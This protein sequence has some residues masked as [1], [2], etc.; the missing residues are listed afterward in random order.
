MSPLI[1]LHDPL[2]LIGYAGMTAPGSIAFLPLFHPA[3]PHQSLVLRA[4]LSR[5]LIP[6]EHRAKFATTNGDAPPTHVETGRLLA[7]IPS[8][9][10][11]NLRGGVESRDVVY[12]VLVRRD[13]YDR[14][15][16]GI[17]TPGV[18]AG[19]IVLP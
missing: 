11:R 7:K 19:R 13:V 17:L 3:T 8:D 5:D 12:L 15:E 4:R 2:Q 9:V 1:D 18:G 10:A 6:P 16:S 14:A